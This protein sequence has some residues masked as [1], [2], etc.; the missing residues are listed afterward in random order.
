MAH[1][2]NLISAVIYG[3]LGVLAIWGAYCA[4]LAWRRIGVTRFRSEKQQSEFLDEI[5]KLGAAH[6]WDAAAQ[7][8]NGDRRAVSQLAA[9]A[10]AQ[11]DAEPAKLRQRV[12]ERFEREVLGELDYRISWIATVIK[13]APM[14]GLLGTVMGMMGAF[15]SLAAGNQVDTTRMAEDIGFALITTASGL[16]IAIPL[17]LCTAVIHVQLRRLEELVA[18]GV[19]EVVEIVSASR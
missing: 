6:Q 11:K 7:R 14:V 13:A 15:A 10:I 2:F 18:V 12:W 5:R 8:C 1:L 19:Q 4:V 17:V 9:I 16:G 3:L